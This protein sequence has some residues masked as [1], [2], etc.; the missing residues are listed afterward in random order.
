VTDAIRQG[1]LGTARL[2][3]TLVA[4]LLAVVLGLPSLLFLGVVALGFALVGEVSSVPDLDGG[5]GEV[6]GD[7]DATAAT[8]ATTATDATDDIE[9]DADADATGDAQADTEVGGGS[10]TGLRLDRALEDARVRPGRSVDGDAV[11][12]Q[13]ERPGRVGRSRR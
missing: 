8:E 9:T 3:V 10:D 12:D 4:A 5:E 1:S 2:V 13:R 6:N 7:T 11:G